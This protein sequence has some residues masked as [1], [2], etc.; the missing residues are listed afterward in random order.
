[1]Q[2]KG[3]FIHVSVGKMYKRKV[4]CTQYHIPKVQVTVSIPRTQ[5]CVFL[6]EANF[7]K[8]NSI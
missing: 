7:S 8:N 4:Y 1:M 5:N 2:T 6:M 3:K